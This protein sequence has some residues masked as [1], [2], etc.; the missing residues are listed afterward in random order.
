M[1][2]GF[3]IDTI[4]HGKVHMTPGLRF[5]PILSGF[6]VLPIFRSCTAALC[7]LAVGCGE[8]AALS[9]GDVSFGRSDLLGLSNSR[10]E[11]LSMITAIGIATARGE[12]V[13]A[14]SAIIERRR[15]DL[16]IEQLR[17]EV[18]PCRHNPGQV[19]Q[20][21]GRAALRAHTASA[22]LSHALASQSSS[23]LA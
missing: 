22:F 23:F 5:E 7:I 20:G 9:I 17:Q 18:T 15:E 11:Q 10:V 14:G 19:A 6:A 4:V 1:F 8:E 2:D 12:G 13:H 21:V 16:L 3:S